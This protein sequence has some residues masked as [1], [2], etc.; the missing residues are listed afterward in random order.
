MT[1]YRLNDWP[2]SLDDE[3]KH[4]CFWFV[5]PKLSLILNKIDLQTDSSIKD[6]NAPCFSL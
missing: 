3:T 5:T 6:R 2:K 4:Y 1:F